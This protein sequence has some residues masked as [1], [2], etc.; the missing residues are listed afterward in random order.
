M[1]INLPK[2]LYA[3][4]GKR[5]VLLLHAYSG[6]SNDV[7]MLA[8]FLEK[9]DYTVY[10]PMFDGHGTLDPEDI[11]TQTPEN[12]WENTKQAVS[13][14]NKEGFSE[15]AVFGL[16]MGG[17][18]AVRTIEECSVLGGGFFCSPIMP[19]ET[20]V[21]E[22][23]EKYAGQVL[24]TAGKTETEINEKLTAMRPKIKEQ[25]A[26]IEAQAAIAAEKLSEISVPVFMAQAGKDQMIDPM[27]IFET[28]R[29]L[30]EQRTVL[31][32]Y[33][34]SPH[35]ITVGNDRRELEEDV[36]DFLNKLPWNEEN[37]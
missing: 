28:A 31:Q 18:F 7:R 32:W 33:P 12:W 26:A 23:F 34:N 8:R 30:R 17:I 27:G 11:L 20:N 15:I 4:H 14:L 13:F 36:L 35:V 25:L 19:V 3:P 21:P 24:K 6:S 22:N 1:K 37:I 16:S 9:A 10:A 2:E 5:A 29:A